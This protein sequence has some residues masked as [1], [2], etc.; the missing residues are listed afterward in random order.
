MNHFSPRN[1]PLTITV[2][3]FAILVHWIPGCQNA[4]ELD[5]SMVSGGQWWRILTGHLTHFDSQHLFWDLVMFTGLGELV[6]RCVR[7]RSHSCFR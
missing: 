2:S 7:V 6:R 4:L 5:F 3:L 1:Y